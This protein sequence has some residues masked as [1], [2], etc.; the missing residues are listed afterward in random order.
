VTFSLLAVLVFAQGAAD[1]PGFRG[2]AGDG[3]A[4]K[5]AN[6]PVEWSESKNVLWKTELPARGRS[7]PVILGDRVFVTGA[8]ESGVKRAKIGP[9]DMQTAEQIVLTVACLDRASGKVIWNA[10]LREID[11]PDPVH[12]LNSWATPTPALEPGRLFCEFGGFGTWCL[13]PESGKILW[14]KRIPMDAQ[15][16]PA[17]SPVLWRDL[18]LLVRDGREAQYVA[19]LDKK[20]GEIVWKTAR[21]P[22]QVNNANS[23][24]SF[25]SPLV[26]EAGGRTQVV[27]IGPHWL[28]AYDPA[29]GKE[30]WKLRHGDGY[31]IGSVP[32]FGQG[33][34]YVGTGCSRPNL[35]SVKP[36]GEGD[37]TSTAINWRVTKG[38]PMISSPLL[39]GDDLYWVSDDGVATCAESKTGAVRWQ[40][41]LG[42]G[43][44]AS[45]M[46]AGGRVYFF[47]KEGKT[48]VVKPGAAFE[49][50]A[51]NQVEGVVIATPAVAG[52]SLYLRTDTHLYRLESR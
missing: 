37:V 33:T 20:S 34:L 46:Y 1:W 21:P 47:G 39:G 43:H 12:W 36:D 26:I 48:T 17:S 14:E 40:S 42:E 45:P 23:K 7:S 2:P 35:I 4:A 11:K 30:L 41:R 18:L 44:L 9:D 25:S 13:D 32:V 31:S 6:P 49:R 38:I 3:V 50:L 19:A 28:V 10:V 15:V 52:K 27:A 16:G 8:R 22:V 24:K 29:T 51:E 5:D